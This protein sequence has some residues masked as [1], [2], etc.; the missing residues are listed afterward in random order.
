MVATRPN[1]AECKRILTKYQGDPIGFQVDCLDV[2]RKHVWGKMLE[3]AES[4]RDKPKTAV[5]AGHGVSKS[6]EAARLAL[7]FL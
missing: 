6:Y 3:V 5:K 4:V 7:W 1:K 2:N